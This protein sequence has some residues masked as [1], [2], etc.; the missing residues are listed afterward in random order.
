MPLEVWK[1]IRGDAVGEFLQIERAGV[2]DVLAR[3]DSR[4]QKTMAS[5]AFT[6][7]RDKRALWYAVVI[8]NPLSF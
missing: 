2:G 6:D 5:N 7:K 4:W 1:N 3:A 8:M